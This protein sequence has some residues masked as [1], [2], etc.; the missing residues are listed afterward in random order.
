MKSIVDRYQV[1][2]FENFKQIINTIAN[3]KNAQIF[4]CAVIGDIFKVAT[5]KRI[6]L[7]DFK[8]LNSD[9]QIAMFI[10]TAIEILK[11]SLSQQLIL[12]DKVNTDI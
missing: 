9:E 1:V 8:K 7:F 4:N 10:N 11:N 5:Q 12:F 2:D 6:V 3:E